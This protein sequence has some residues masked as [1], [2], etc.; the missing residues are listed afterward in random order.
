MGEKLEMEILK[1]FIQMNNSR[2]RIDPREKILKATL[3]KMNMKAS[4]TKML[5]DDG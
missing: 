5:H 3:I 2:T 1:H 4:I